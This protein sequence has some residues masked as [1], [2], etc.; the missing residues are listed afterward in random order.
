LG[1]NPSAA[2]QAAFSRRFGPIEGQDRS[3][4]CHPGD[5]DVL[6]RCFV[7]PSHVEPAMKLFLPGAFDEL[8]DLWIGIHRFKKSCFKLL[9]DSELGI[10]AGH[11]FR[12]VPI[13]AITIEPE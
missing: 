5:E 6:L 9:A 3:N 1:Q 8:P 7:P 11:F 2:Q 10:A 12:L 13:G 4:Y